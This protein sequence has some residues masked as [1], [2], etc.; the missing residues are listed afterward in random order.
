MRN[1][2]FIPHHNFDKV[3]LI[4][5]LA[6]P[7]FGGG[8]I[9][10]PIT[11]NVGGRGISTIGTDAIPINEIVIESSIGYMKKALRNFDER[12]LRTTPFVGQGSSDLI[13]IFE[14]SAEMPLANDTSFGVGHYP[15]SML[16]NAVLSTERYINRELNRVMPMIGE[17]V[18]VMGLRIRD[19]YT[20]TVGA[21]IID[22]YVSDIREYENVISNLEEE[23]KDFTEGLVDGTLVVQANMGDDV[24]N[25]IVYLT[26]I[27]TSAENGDDGMCGRGNRANGLI[28]P[29]RPMSLEGVAGK[30]PISHVGK[31]YNVLA[32]LASRQ[33]V[34][35]T[36]AREAIV[37]LLSEIGQPIDQP[38]DADIMLHLHRD[39]SSS[40]RDSIKKRAIAILDDRLAH[41]RDISNMILKGDVSVF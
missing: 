12:D 36:G 28:T 9:L 20:L 29:Y 7:H 41:V 17:D 26:V 31:L 6:D 3:Q 16:E 38:L 39:T 19:R 34:E 33:I 18:K 15:L 32:M 8:E 5:G 1:F 37:H 11:I 13:D 23:I 25:G 35:E 24:K 40:E 4:A 27:G 10:A 22:R 21:P 30:N 14:R 2:G